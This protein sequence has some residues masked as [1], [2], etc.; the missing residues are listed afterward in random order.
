MINPIASTPAMVPTTSSKRSQHN[1]NIVGGKSKRNRK[2]PTKFTFDT[3]GKAVYL[4]KYPI[5]YDKTFNREP[6]VDSITDEHLVSQYAV[7]FNLC[8]NEGTF[9]IPVKQDTIAYL[10]RIDK[11]THIQFN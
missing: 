7:Y 5:I 1:W 3:S 2:Q 9:N 10:A 6:P 8:G 4:T 11:M